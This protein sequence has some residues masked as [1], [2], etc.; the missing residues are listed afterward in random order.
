MS[1][2][3]ERIEFA[4]INFGVEKRRQV[5]ANVKDEGPFYNPLSKRFYTQKLISHEEDEE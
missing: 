2:D 5:I 3:K 1:K 4:R